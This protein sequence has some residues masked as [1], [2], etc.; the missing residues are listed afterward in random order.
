MYNPVYVSM[1]NESKAA[2]FEYDKKQNQQSDIRL[3]TYPAMFKT[4]YRK[5]QFTKL[6]SLLLF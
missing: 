4:Q 3:E 6:N 1:L 2:I 5:Q